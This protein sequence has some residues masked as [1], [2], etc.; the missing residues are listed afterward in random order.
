MNIVHISDLHF[1]PRHW[2]GINQLLLEKINSFNAD[3]VINTGDNTTD[4]LESEYVQAGNFLKGIRCENIISTLGNHDKRNMR[5]H[6]L[7]QEHIDNSEIITIS[8]NIKT[9]KKH[10]FLNLEITKLN[11]H[12]TDINFVKSIEI[13]GKKVLVIS[14][15]SNELYNDDGY[16]EEEVLNAVSKVIKQTDY[17]I[18]LLLTHYSVLGTDECPLKNSATLID[19][20]QKHKI[21]YVFCGHTHE[22]ELMRTNDL[23]H[24]HTFDQY[25]CGTLSARNHA[26]DDNMFLYYENLGTKDM[27][28]HLIRIFP[29]KDNLLFKEEM[30]Y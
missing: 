7:F 10:L 30:V 2:D 24:G 27:H 5:S 25:M 4:G 11:D 18:P 21:K 23:Y 3:I 26:K 19:F 20:I 29:D 12:F 17:D 15:D 1:G 6:E 22:L 14:I 8:K 16:V 13:K 28:L 9:S